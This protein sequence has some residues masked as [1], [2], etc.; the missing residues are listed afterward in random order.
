MEKDVFKAT[1][2]KKE[3]DFEC[4]LWWQIYEYALIIQ[5][6]NWIRIH[7]KSSRYVLL[8]TGFASYSLS[9][10]ASHLMNIKFADSRI[11]LGHLVFL[12]SFF[13]CNK[14]VQSVE[15]LESHQLQE[16]T[17]KLKHIQ[18]IFKITND[19]YH[20]DATTFCSKF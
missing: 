14:A 8:N 5:C 1:T 12:V 11:V 19:I 13:G 9:I 4:K 3:N 17:F 10:D 15:H 16:I 18:F 20:H 6:T 2:T 7:A